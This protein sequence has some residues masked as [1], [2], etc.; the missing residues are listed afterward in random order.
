MG[1]RQAG[2]AVKQLAKFRLKARRHINRFQRRRSPFLESGQSW[3]WEL[4]RCL[5]VKLPVDAV[6]SETGGAA[7]ACRKLCRSI[8]SEARN[9]RKAMTNS[10]F[11]GGK[12]NG[13]FWPRLFGFASLGR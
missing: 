12:G 10:L 11:T 2:A 6:N 9:N 8:A 3:G 4:H 1:A 5:W 7:R 13:C